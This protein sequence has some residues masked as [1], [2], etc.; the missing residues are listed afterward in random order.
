[1]IKKIFVETAWWIGLTSG[2]F[3]LLFFM[4]VYWSG[5]DP[6]GKFD[7]LAY[8]LPSILIAYSVFHRKRFAGKGFIS[9]P[10]GFMTGLLTSFTSVNVAA[11]GIYIVLLIKPEIL[12][13]HIL[14]LELFLDSNKVALIEQSNQK[15]YDEL[16]ASVK[17]T[18]MGS[19]VLD[20]FIK[21]SGIQFLVLFLAAG[22]MRKI[23]L[24][25]YA[26]YE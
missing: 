18:T 26:K 23:N 20:Y 11:I 15:S 17:S 19:M 24:N 3:S 10:E 7:L 8:I 1:M 12:G 21:K 22:F 6:F 13:Q 25:D 9:F 4:I 16:V 14:E 2:L 5:N